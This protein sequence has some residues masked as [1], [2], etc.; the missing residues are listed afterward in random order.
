LPAR[1]KLETG[2]LRK[3]AR[4]FYDIDPGEVIEKAPA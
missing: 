1:R 4:Q 2:S 3:W